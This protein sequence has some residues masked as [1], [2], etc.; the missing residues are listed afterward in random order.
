VHMRWEDPDTHQVIEIEKEIYAD[1]FERDFDD[2]DP[3]FQRSVIVAEY[4]EILGESFW[5]EDSDLDDVYDEA[6]RLEDYFRR[7]DAMEEFVD[8]VKEAKRG[9]W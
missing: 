1:E 2:A 7:E 4:A 8:L 6:R 3:Y 5:A 9:W